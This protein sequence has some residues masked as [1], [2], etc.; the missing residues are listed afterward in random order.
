MLSRALD[1]GEAE[2][3]RERGGGCGKKRERDEK[4]SHTRA[5]FGHFRALAFDVGQLGAIKLTGAAA[6]ARRA[7]RFPFTPASG[8]T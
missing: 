3:L 5:S 1:V 7:M 2:R 8:F 4:P 6:C